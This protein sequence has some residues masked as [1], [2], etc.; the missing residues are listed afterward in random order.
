[1]RMGSDGTTLRGID[2]FDAALSLLQAAWA[3]TRGIQVL[4]VRRNR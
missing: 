3:R 4:E 1:M 2:H